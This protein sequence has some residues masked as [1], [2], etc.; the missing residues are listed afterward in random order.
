MNRED[1]LQGII[2]FQ[3]KQIKELE[4]EIKGM[5]RDINVRD[6]DIEDLKRELSNP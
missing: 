4:A 6:S 3:T 5:E 2:D 1:E